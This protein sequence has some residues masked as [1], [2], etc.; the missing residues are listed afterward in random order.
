MA[1]NKRKPDLRAGALSLL[2]VAALAGIDQLLKAWATAALAGGGAPLL[3]GLL[4][5]RYVL[6][7]GMAFSMLSGRRWL[8]LGATGLI[9]AVVVLML[10]LRPLPRAERVVWV[11]V[12][13]GGIGNF[14]DRARTGAVVDYL[15]FLFIDFPVFNFAD[16][17]V[18][19]GVGLLLVL[20]AAELRRE[21]R[22]GR[23][24]DP[25]AHA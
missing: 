11:L 21:H 7:D 16:I 8:L 19:V 9:L 24:Q 12:A 25:D 2:G 22:A 4:E 1:E 13:G 20:L 10:L 6:N 23:R 3:P 18:T 15:N 17:C 5:L 14:I